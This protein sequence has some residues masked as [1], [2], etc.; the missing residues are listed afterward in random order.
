MDRD[1]AVPRVRG[2][3]YGGDEF[4]SRRHYCP[5]SPHFREASV[6]IAEELARRYGGHPALA[7]WHVGNEYGGHV[8]ECFCETSADHFRGWLAQ[9]YG[10]VDDLNR[11]WGTAF[12]GQ[13]YGDYAQIE[14]PRRTPPVW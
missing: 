3:L 6:R 9:R 11:A 8:T 4:G 13:R 10:S 2:L 1:P 14:P 12:W 7:M 5:S